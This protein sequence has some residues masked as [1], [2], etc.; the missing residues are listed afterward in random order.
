MAPVS[1]LGARLYTFAPAEKFM[2]YLKIAMIAGAAFSAPFFITQAGLFIWPGLV[3]S[4]R[5][6]AL[7][8]LIAAPMLFLSGSAAAYRFFSPTVLRFFL[9]FGSG[10]GVE[11][12][13]G[14]GQYLSL[15]ANLML[16]AGLLLQLPLVLTVLFALGVVSPGRVASMRPYVI[17]LIFFLAGILTP[18]DA[19]SQVMLGVPLYL[20]FELTLLA[21]IFV[22][23][24]RSGRDDG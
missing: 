23:P 17:M 14:F 15:L 1:G 2:A 8:S 4:E 9:S 5:K 20:V 3:R 10:D 7:I 21:G 18:P 16:A 12:M 13:W 11:P 24:R 22:S 6:C 19:T